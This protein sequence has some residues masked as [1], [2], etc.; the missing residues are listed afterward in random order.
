MTMKTTMS[1][2][3]YRKDLDR[4]L[5]AWQRVQR[6]M[7]AQEQLKQRDSQAR[8][9]AEELAKRLERAGIDAEPI[10]RL[11]PELLKLGLVSGMSKTEAD[12][13]ASTL[14]LQ[15]FHLRLRGTAN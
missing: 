13:W 8:S 7:E 6:D 1:E 15:A 2:G 5:D 3:D 14:T 12:K 11:R 9:N 4:F 10:L